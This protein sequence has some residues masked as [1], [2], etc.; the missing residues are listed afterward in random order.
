MATVT[1]ALAASFAFALP[2]ALGRVPLR[3]IAL[4]VADVLSDFGF[5]TVVPAPSYGTLADWLATGEVHAAWAPPAVCAHTIAAGGSVPLRA[6]RCGAT[7]YRGALLCRSDR[8][9]DLKSLAD[10]T[11]LSAVRAVWVDP[12]SSAG[13]RAPRALL[14]ARGIALGR[15]VVEQFAG[16]Y[17]ACFDAVL[18]GDADLTATFVGRNGAGYVD[19]C[20][21]RAAGL[22]VLAWTDEIPNDGIAVSPALSPG[23]RAE[24]EAAL[25]AAA[26]DDRTLDRLAPAFDVDRF[27]PA[28]AAAYAAWRAVAGDAACAAGAGAR[29]RAG[30]DRA[31]THH[32]RAAAR[33]ANGVHVPPSA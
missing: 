2:P 8:P 29:H 32:G 31:R 11:G 30:R 10:A 6:V 24:V 4:R 15:A 12:R 19:L 23:A 26:D 22:R 20:G 18:A 28:D 14:R 1:I 17:A 7:T 27:D 13:F 9:V 33:P 3:K 21:D 5:G 16:S 25:R